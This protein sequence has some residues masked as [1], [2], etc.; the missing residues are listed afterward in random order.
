LFTSIRFRIILKKT[1][2]AILSQKEKNN[3]IITVGISS[4]VVF[5]VLL[6]SSSAVDELRDEKK[7]EILLPNSMK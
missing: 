3:V 6:F 7:L 5:V 1:I 2:F 4:L